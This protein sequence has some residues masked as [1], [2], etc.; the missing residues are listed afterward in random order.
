M[1]TV[2][3]IAKL[4]TD[5]VGRIAWIHVGIFSFLLMMSAWAVGYHAR[6]ASGGQGFQQDNQQ[7]LK[8]YTRDGRCKDATDFANRHPGGN[9]I[10]KANGKKIEDHSKESGKTFHLTNG[11]VDVLEKLPDCINE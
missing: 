11:A 2:H 8:I 10:W 3:H 6:M 5:P 7:R 1:G 4:K 9:V